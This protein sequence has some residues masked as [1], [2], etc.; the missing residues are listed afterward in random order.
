M[1]VANRASCWVAV[2]RNGRITRHWFRGVSGTLKDSKPNRKGQ[3]I[4]P[5]VNEVGLSRG[6][7]MCRSSFPMNSSRS[8]WLRWGCAFAFGLAACKP[9]QPPQDG[10]SPPMAPAQRSAL[11]AGTIGAEPEAVVTGDS[12]IVHGQGWAVPVGWTLTAT[13]G[14]PRIAQLRTS[15]G[16]EILVF[17]FGHGGGTIQANFQRWREQLQPVQ[18]SVIEMDTAMGEI[19]AIGRWTGNYRG[20]DGSEAADGSRRTLLGAVVEGPGG[21]IFFKSVGEKEKFR[22]EGDRIVRWIRSGKSRP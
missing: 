1:V 6:G 17:S 15:E 8:S 22:K 7:Q 14:H 20:G 3:R 2:V 21:R 5:S 4:A 19:R 9:A 13:H 16:L 10:P 12:L 11:L 18:D